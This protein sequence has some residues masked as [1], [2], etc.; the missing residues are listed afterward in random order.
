MKP[1]VQRGIVL[2]PVAAKL[3]SEATGRKVR[4]WKEAVRHPK[5]PVL[6]GHIDR[7]IVSGDG[8]EGP[9]V[10]E[11]KCPGLRQFA[12]CKR[13]GL[14]DQY[15]IQLQHYL[16][17]TGRDWG[18]VLVFSA[19]LWQMI[20]FDI[21]RDPELIDL[22]VSKGLAFWDRIETGNPPPPPELAEKIVLP[23]LTSSQ[24]VMDMSEDPAWAAAIENL[25][26]AKEIMEEAR[27]LEES[28]KGDVM[29]IMA[30]AGAEIAEGA[31]TR[32]YFRERPGRSRLDTAKLK[33]EMPEVW[34]Q[35]SQTGEAYKEFRAY[36]LKGGIQNE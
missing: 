27:E 23:K 12:S 5:W 13:S 7:S 35:Y 10:L 32:C 16:A 31:G 17:C 9:G 1:A 30:R 36:F 24:Q 4:R 14:P 29:S 33:V 6:F 18:A 11:I 28:A 3:Y 26:Y 34:K 21:A 20:Y 8:L 15:T 22:I 2:E 19:E 25:G